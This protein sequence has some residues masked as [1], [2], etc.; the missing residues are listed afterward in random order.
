MD[1]QSGVVLNA[2]ATSGTSHPKQVAPCLLGTKHDVDKPPLM[3]G[4]TSV[5]PNTVNKSLAIKWTSPAERQN[6]LNKWLCFNFADA[7]DNVK[8]GDISIFNSLVG[9]G[10]PRSL[11]IWERLGQRMSMVCTHFIAYEVHEVASSLEVAEPTHLELEH[12]LTRF[13]SL[14]QPLP[15]PTIAWEDV[16]MDFILGMPLSKEFTIVLVVVDRFSKYAHFAMFPSMRIL[17]KGSAIYHF[18]STWFFKSGGC[19]CNTPKI[20]SQRNSNIGVRLQGTRDKSQKTTS[21]ETFYKM[22]HSI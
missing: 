13:D 9:H 1:R 18:V 3:S 5:S 10:S 22:S 12:L 17:W 11:Q 2:P 4:L 14:F 16:S 20:W 6:H 19:G 7:M 8:S 21:K 15:T